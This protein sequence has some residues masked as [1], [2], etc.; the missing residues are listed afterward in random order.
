MT[1]KWTDTQIETTLGQIQ[2]EP[3]PAFQHRMA[4]APWQANPAPVYVL[5]PLRTLAAVAAAFVLL[6]VAMVYTPLGTLAQELL[7]FFTRVGSS[8]VPYSYTVN[9][10]PT[11]A[12]AGTVWQPQTLSDVEA[13]AGF[14]VLA[15]QMIPTGYAFDGADFADDVV[16]LYFRMP[17]DTLGRNLVIQEA[18]VG[19][20]TDMEIGV[21]AP[22]E[23]VSIDGLSGEYV[24]GWWL[25]TGSETRVDDATRSGEM[26]WNAELGFHF[27]RFERDGLQVQVLYQETGNVTK[28]QDT[29]A[30]PGYLTKTDL[31]NIA[32]GLK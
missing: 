31:V 11:L 29:S 6:M 21:G 3:G 4:K 32:A 19:V 28:I 14:D 10:E 18:R 8:T 17:G 2:P 13:K 7:S 1:H 9:P 25:A 12:A 16:Y 5:K 23:L 30:Q 27:L 24:T 20:D 15:P 22:V 26:T